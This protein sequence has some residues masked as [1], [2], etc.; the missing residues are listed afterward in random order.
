MEAVD[1]SKDC[2]VD[3]LLLS[4]TEALMKENQSGSFKSTFNSEHTVKTR[5][6]P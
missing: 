5:R 6:A 2:R 4:A 3:W 1:N